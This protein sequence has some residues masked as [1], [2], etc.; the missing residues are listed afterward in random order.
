MLLRCADT[1][2]RMGREAPCGPASLAYSSSISVEIAAGGVR[3]SMPGPDCGS[4]EHRDAEQRGPKAATHEDLLPSAFSRTMP[5][6]EDTSMTCP[7]RSPELS[8]R[9]RS[10]CGG[11]GR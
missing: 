2:R 3:T 11:S 6:E 1:A 5:R 10:A 9:P 7:L 8:P 4:H